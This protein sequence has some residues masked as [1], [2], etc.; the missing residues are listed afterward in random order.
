MKINSI[1]PDSNDFTIPLSNI[2]TPPKRLFYKGYL[3]VERRPTV[4][5]VG[6][7]KPTAYGEEVTSAFSYELARHGVVIVSGLAL[8][9]DTIAHTSALEAGGTTIA[10]LGHG[11][12]SIY[13]VGNRALAERIVMHGGALISEYSPDTP[14]RPWQFLQRNRLVSGLADALIITEA[15]ARSGTLST[16]MHALDQGKDIFVIPGNITSPMS[17][18]CNALLKQGANLATSPQDILEHILPNIT[19]DQQSLPLGATAEETRIIALLGEGI[20]DG[21]VLQQRTSIEAAQFA[22]T[23]TM[24]EL[25]GIIRSIGGN[26]WTLR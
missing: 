15:A 10:V 2:I 26:Q 4:A 9:I 1:T 19:P 22:T 18:G 21:E 5:I 14:G 24:L 11:L 23:L 3:P 12:A 17:A 7:R 25:N 6:T 16:A 13:P 20:R 8:G